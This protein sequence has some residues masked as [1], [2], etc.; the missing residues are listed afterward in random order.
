MFISQ[1]LQTIALTALVCEIIRSDLAD[2]STLLANLRREVW[3][4]PATCSVCLEALED[5]VLFVSCQHD[6]VVDQECLHHM[7]QSLIRNA[8]QHEIRCPVCEVPYRLS[9]LAAYLS[10]AGFD[11]MLQLERRRAEHQ[12]LSN[13]QHQAS[14]S[15]TTRA[16]QQLMGLLNLKCPECEQVFVDFD[17]CFA[18]VCSRCQAGFCG[19]CLQACSRNAAQHHLHVQRC[20]LGNGKLYA[21]LVDFNQ[22]HRQRQREHVKL[23]L[24]L[25]APTVRNDVVHK[26]RHQLH[27]LGLDDLVISPNET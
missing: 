24:S 9:Y 7:L 12:V 16:Y 11:H 18:L 21:S 22:H 26:A 27:D 19:W 10:P 6:H 17:G 23:Y 4:A 5:D 8:D 25:M 2:W 3:W 1:V 13:L 14:E 15:E 20:P